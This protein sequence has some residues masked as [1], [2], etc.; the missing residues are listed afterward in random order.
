MSGRWGPNER[1]IRER[2]KDGEGDEGREH[3]AEGTTR[4]RADQKGNWVLKPIRLG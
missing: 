3:D 4:E 2:E 1:E